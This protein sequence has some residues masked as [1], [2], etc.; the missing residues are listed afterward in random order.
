MRCLRGVALIGIILL[1]LFLIS[2]GV[3]KQNSSELLY[4][5][6]REA[7]A[8]LQESSVHGWTRMP[9]RSWTVAALQ[10][11]IC[12]GIIAQGEKP[13][14]Y[15]FETNSTEEHDIVRAVKV[16]MDRR[17]AIATTIRKDDSAAFMMV[18]ISGSTDQISNLEQQA[19]KI[20][21]STGGIP[22]I[23]SCLV[24]WINGKLNNGEWGD[25]LSHSFA[26]LNVKHINEM[27]DTKVSSVSGYS[28]RLNG[29]LVIGDARVNINMASRYSSTDNR[30]YITLGTPI[31]VQEY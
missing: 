16:T 1:P 10:S 17:E 26:L 31:I 24:G 30:T 8:N 9:S 3:S 28:P 15:Q 12:Q 14:S 29:G 20:L 13:E 21:Y 4:R 11:S 25:I 22:K 19:A 7:G 27:N 23:N 5:V 6:L 2:G 18:T